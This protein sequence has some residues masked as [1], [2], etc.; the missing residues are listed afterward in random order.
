MRSRQAIL[1]RSA[2]A[3]GAALLA[4]GCGTATSAAADAGP[5]SPAAAAAAGPAGGATPGAACSPGPAASVPAGTLTGLQFTSAAAGWAVGQHVILATTDGG[6]RWR[7]QLSGQLNLTSV[8]FVNGQDGW[9]VGAGTLLATSDGGASWTRLA[10][11]C[12]VIR[13]VHFTSPV[14]GFAVAGGSSLASPGP[15]PEVPQLGGVV[16]ATSDGGRSWHSLATPADAQTVC[17]ADPAHGWLGAGGLLYRSADG[18]GHW[19]ALTSMAGQAGSASP[20]DPAV[21]NVQCAGAG[22]A[23]A[24]RVGPGAAM[25]QQPHVGF[26][27]DQAGATAVFAEQYFQQPGAK[28]AGQAPGSY[29]GPFSAIS[30]ASAAFVDWCTACGTGTAPWDTAVGSGAVLTPQGDV[31]AI[32]SPEAASFQSPARGWVAGSVLDISAA[33]QTR[34]QQRIVATTDGGR[35][36]AVQYAGPW[37]A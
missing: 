17:F 14:T 23:W 26:H 11:P 37:S 5:G 8:D 33:G 9:A 15:G 13:S 28:P 6:A 3:A 2:L 35:S 32:S 1:V 29:A 20:A 18:G 36:W 24:L 21:M 31:G 34:T 12:P 30:P 19:T 7:A 22:A 4:V 16:L 25:S 10:E 27:A